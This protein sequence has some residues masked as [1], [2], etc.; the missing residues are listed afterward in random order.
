MISIQKKNVVI[1]ILE[2]FSKEYVGYYNNGSGYTTFLDSIIPH[3]LVM[4]N[5][6]ANGIKS[7]EA[8]PAITSSVPTLMNEPFITSSY[9]TNS[10]YSIASLLKKEGYSTSFFHGGTRGTMGFYQ[11]SK[12]AGFDKYF[13]LEEYGKE[14][15]NDGVWGIYDGP[16]FKYFSDYLNKEQQKV[17]KEIMG[18]RPEIVT[19]E[20]I[21]YK[22]KQV[23]QM[24]PKIN[25]YDDY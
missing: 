8:L 1:I 14:K 12:K 6:Y 22:E 17:I 15:D 3:S 23:K 10:Y 11:F 9:A 24:K 13:G 5:G 16:F 19:K 7:I 4:E 2:S 25:T 21:I 20:K 18:I